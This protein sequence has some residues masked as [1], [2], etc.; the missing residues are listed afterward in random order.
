MEK[1]IIIPFIEAHYV[2]YLYYEN[3]VYILELITW[4]ILVSDIDS[5]PYLKIN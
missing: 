2:I 5:Y 4:Y 1:N 3:Y